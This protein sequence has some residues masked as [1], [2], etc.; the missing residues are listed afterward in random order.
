MNK[1][2][3][4]SIVM[5]AVIILA[6]AGDM[7]LAADLSY[8]DGGGLGGQSPIAIFVKR[9]VQLGGGIFMVHALM[10]VASDDQRKRISVGN[11]VL[12]WFCAICAIAV[13]QFTQMIANTFNNPS[14][15]A[16]AN[17]FAG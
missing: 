16:L 8:G 13:D 1:N 11:F 12:R 17:F 6:L 7:A 3:M 9:A 15:T 10:S 5:I 4:Q 14:T 2:A